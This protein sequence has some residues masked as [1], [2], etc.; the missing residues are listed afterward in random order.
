[1][2]KALT[3]RLTEGLMR[4]FVEADPDIGPKMKRA[5]KKTV[6]PLTQNFL[7]KTETKPKA[8][9]NPQGPVAEESI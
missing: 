3:A 9:E 1:M 8:R 7:A 5:I 4:I 2:K 6:G